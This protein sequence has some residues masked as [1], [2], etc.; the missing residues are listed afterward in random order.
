MC[1][2]PVW[3]HALWTLDLGQ[4]AGVLAGWANH[5][6]EPLFA[7]VGGGDGRWELEPSG[8]TMLVI[9]ETTAAIAPLI[10]LRN[11]TIDAVD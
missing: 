9:A 6:S 2:L 11:T 4:H 8:R 5:G 1:D 3:L 10:G 7:A